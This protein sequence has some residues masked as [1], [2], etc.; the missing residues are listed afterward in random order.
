MVEMV[1]EGGREQTCCRN[2]LL[3]YIGE[4]TNEDFEIFPAVLRLEA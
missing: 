1:R 4:W 3:S 2:S